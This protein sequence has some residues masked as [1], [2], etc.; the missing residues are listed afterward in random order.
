[1]CNFLLLLNVW[2]LFDIPFRLI[3]LKSAIFLTFKIFYT[4]S[5]N[6]GRCC[7][8]VIL[9]RHCSAQGV[10]CSNYV[11]KICSLKTFVRKPCSLSYCHVLTQQRINKEKEIYDRKIA[12]NPTTFCAELAATLRFL[13]KM[14]SQFCSWICNSI[15]IKP[16]RH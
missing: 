13:P 6:W 5:D 11:P 2:K 15:S 8:D 12:K 1:M 4:F 14:T 3:L 9:G 16:K 10:F 7:C